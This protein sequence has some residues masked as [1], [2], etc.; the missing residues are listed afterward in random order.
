M[1]FSY[2]LG[3]PRQL[4]LA[5]TAVSLVE[6]PVAHLLLARWNGTVAVAV[7]VASAAFIAYILTDWVAAVRRPIRLEPDRLVVRRGLRRPTE[8]PLDAIAGVRIVPSSDRLPDGALRTLYAGEATVLVTL[9]P[10]GAAA[11][12]RAAVAFA[13]DDPSALVTALVAAGVESRG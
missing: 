13:P 3:L 5:V 10:T 2:A 7:T 11:L 8:V 12:G 9:T 4:V 1:T 6:I